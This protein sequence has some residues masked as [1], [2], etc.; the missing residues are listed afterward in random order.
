[1]VLKYL[2]SSLGCK[3]NQYEAEELNNFLK[4]CSLEETKENTLPDFVFIHTCAVTNSAVSQSLQLIRRYKRLYPLA[5]I[6]ITG[7]GCAVKDFNTVEGVWAYIKPKE[8]WLD[9]IAILIN[10]NNFFIN[11]KYYI[12]RCS[13]KT[14][15]F[16]KIQDGC[17]LGCSYCIVGKIRGKPRDKNPQEVL[18]GARILADNGYKELVVCGVSVGLYG[19]RGNSIE[20]EYSLSN[21]LEKLLYIDNIKRIRLSSLHP[22]E[23][24]D[25]LLSIWLKSSRMMPHLHLPLQSGSDR[26][27][28]LMNR[29]YSIK[30]YLS[31]IEKCRKYINNPSI[32]TDIIVGFPGETKEDFAS[33]VNIIDHVG[34][35][36][37]HIF[38]F[39]SRPGTEAATMAGALERSLIKERCA[40]LKQKADDIANKHHQYFIG[41]K[42]KVLIESYDAKEGVYKG[43]S[44][45]YFIVKI[46]NSGLEA[47]A[48]LENKIMDVKITA[49]YKD[50][51]NGVI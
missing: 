9:E 12:K 48:V 28:R 24:T 36:R 11:K 23:L 16:L 41:L 32:S 22:Q 26:I 46:I 31:S 43:H 47:K 50:Y 29:R 45:R 33:T 1:M 34:F 40:I 17:D 6:I 42:E 7:C 27:L 30:E 25:D 14:R 15:A 2:V 3:V 5:K 4:N 39:S 13:G 49:A 19:K 18:Q 37:V 10:D 38:P 21:L 44:E 51:T 8:D 20:N 35:S